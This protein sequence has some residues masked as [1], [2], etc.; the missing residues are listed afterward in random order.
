MERLDDTEIKK[1]LLDLLCAFD[2]I[3][4]ENGLRYSLAY[5]TLLGA[6]RHKG[7]IPWDDDIDVLMPQDDYVRFLALPCFRNQDLDSPV[8]LY[9]IDNV[10]TRNL[11]YLYPFA[12]LVDGRT[13]IK[14]DCFR[15]VGGIWMDIF[16]V[17]G[18]PAGDSGIRK[19]FARMKRNHLR[20]AA[21]HRYRELGQ[22]SPITLLKQIR[23][24][25]YYAIHKWLV[26]RMKKTAFGIPYANSD[27]AAVSMWNYGMK[28]RMPREYFDGFVKVEFEGKEFFG[29]KRH[30][31]YLKKLYGEWR[32]FPPEDQRVAHHYYEALRK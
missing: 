10:C 1:R 30:D 14:S 4:R 7:F 9:E 17:T 13:V 25:F 18:L 23:C 20:L 27:E 3:C 26:K 21:A 19:H 32:R 15:E 5:G 16:P 29:L 31:D 11:R 6:I 28:E 2:I 8:V 22:C 24:N 12:K